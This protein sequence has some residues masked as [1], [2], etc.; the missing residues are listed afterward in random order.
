MPGEIVCF[1]IQVNDF[2][3][4]IALGLSLNWDPNVY[5]YDH[6]EAFGIPGLDLSGFGTPTPGF[7]DV[8]EGELTMS[9]I[10]LSLEGVTL[11]DFAVI[12]TVCLKA[13]GAAGTSSL[14]TFSQTPLEIE[15]ATIDS[16]L[17]PS[18]LH[19]FGQISA[20]CDPMGCDNL[21]YTLDRTHPQCPW[22]CNGPVSY[23]HL[24]RILKPG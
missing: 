6:L 23:T 16:T 2:D 24:S 17:V 18:L 22:D 4:I 10:D 13:V 20:N 19:G 9:W 5:E 15:A 14:I 1:D 3:D 12:F 11:P 21:S 8:E 7:P